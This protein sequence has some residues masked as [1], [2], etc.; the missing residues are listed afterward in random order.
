MAAT[1]YATQSESPFTSALKRRE[2]EADKILQTSNDARHIRLAEEFLK[3]LKPEE[4]P[5]TRRDS[6]RCL[7]SLDSETKVS[8]LTHA[9]K[10]AF[11]SKIVLAIDSQMSIGFH[12]TP[13][14]EVLMVA[15]GRES[16]AFQR[17]W[18]V[19]F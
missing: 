10:M 19:V 16:L 13:F 8:Q 3:S 2:E 9:D 6:V 7:P 12:N 18:D 4:P 17:L 14:S 15:C 1:P 11:A 5:S